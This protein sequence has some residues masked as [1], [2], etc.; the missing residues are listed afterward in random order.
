MSTE[1]PH[2][3]GV[4]PDLDTLADLQEGLLP[5]SPSAAVSDHLDHCESCRADFVALGRVPA[6][7]A[8]AADVGAMPDELAARL[9]D[10]LAGEPRTASVTITPLASA[11]RNRLPRDNR[12]LQ[13]AAAAV[14][15]MAATAIGISAVQNRG[16]NS[17]AGSNDSAAAGKTAR[18]FSAGSVPVL[19]TGSDYSQAS[20][21]A[22]VPGLLAA[23]SRTLLDS[24]EAGA[25]TRAAGS[26]EAT[27]APTTTSGRA[28]SGYSA[29]LG[30][31]AALSACVIALADDPE[32]AGIEMPTPLAVDV[33]KYDGKPATVIVLPTPEEANQLDVYVVGPGCG[34]SDA[35]LLHFAR[36]PRP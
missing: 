12:V 36:V 5:P 30:E 10:A 32:T 20:V 2:G 26:P 4:H 23:D 22:A 27:D 3:T 6:R 8:A 29:R 28:A 15:V 7:L 17:T 13:A 34:P 33:A 14:L 25:P 18:E 11:R 1:Q 16:E 35:K 9:N 19:S 31:G 24:S 21:A